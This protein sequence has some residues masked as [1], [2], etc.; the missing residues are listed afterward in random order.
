MAAR[1]GSAGAAAR[2]AAKAR[3]STTH[4]T[5]MAAVQGSAISAPKRAKE[6]PLAWNASRLVRF[7]TGSSSD[8][9]LARCV[10]A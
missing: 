4:S 7:E 1:R 6:S 8:A 5:A 3:R 9:E 2:S 10:H